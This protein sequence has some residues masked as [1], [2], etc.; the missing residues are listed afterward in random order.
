MS[1]SLKKGPF[2]DDH[3]LAKIGKMSS[4]SVKKPI[5]TWSR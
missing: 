2:V 3:L 1:R 5:K 4:A